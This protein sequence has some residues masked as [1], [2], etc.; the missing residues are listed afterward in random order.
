MIIY[1]LFGFGEWCGF[2]YVSRRYFV[3]SRFVVN[4]FF[5]RLDEFV[6]EYGVMEVYEVVA[7]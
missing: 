5:V 6:I 7:G 3:D 4:D 2:F 1:F